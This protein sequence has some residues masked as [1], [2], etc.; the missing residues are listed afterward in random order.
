MQ[1]AASFGRKKR[2]GIFGLFCL[3]WAPLAYGQSFSQTQA[4]S[5]GRIALTNYNGVETIT[6]SPDG[7]Y[8]ASTGIIVL[9][10]PAPA[11]FDGNGFAPNTAATLLVTDGS[12]TLGGSGTGSMFTIKDY[13]SSP[14]TIVTN[15]AGSLVFTLGATLRSEGNNTIYTDGNYTTDITVSLVF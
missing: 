8:V 10:D 3:V 2:A 4:M 15:G 9:D 13:V 7:G 6:L 12:A 5:F 14:P 11:R 1:F